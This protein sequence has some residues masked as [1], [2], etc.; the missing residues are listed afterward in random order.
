MVLELAEEEEA[1]GHRDQERGNQDQDDG[2]EM[3]VAKQFGP[4]VEEGVEDAFGLRG[5]TYREEE[6]EQEEKRKLM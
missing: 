6:E 4:G 2:G 5:N 1:A 3:N